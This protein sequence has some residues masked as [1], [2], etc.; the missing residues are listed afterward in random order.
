MNMQ[1]CISVTHSHKESDCSTLGIGGASFAVPTVRHAGDLKSTIFLDDVL[2]LLSTHP[3]YA[4]PATRQSRELR[5]RLEPYSLKPSGTY[6]RLGTSR[7]KRIGIF[8][9][10]TLRSFSRPA[11]KN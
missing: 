9:R 3:V 10:R 7:F 2:P 8:L 11:L 1:K 5:R 6:E 4:T